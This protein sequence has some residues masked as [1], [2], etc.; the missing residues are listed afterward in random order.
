MCINALTSA[1]SAI[2]HGIYAVAKGIG[3]VVSSIC[4]KVAGIAARI[5]GKAP[6]QSSTPAKPVNATPIAESQNPKQ[7]ELG[8]RVHEAAAKKEIGTQTETPTSLVQLLPPKDVCL[9]VQPRTMRHAAVC[10]EIRRPH[11][12]GIEKPNPRIDQQFLTFN[13]EF[14]LFMNLLKNC[15]PITINVSFPKN[16]KPVVP[17]ASKPALLMAPE[18]TPVMAKKRREISSEKLAEIMGFYCNKAQ[19]RMHAALNM[20]GV[21]EQA[22]REA[23]TAQLKKSKLI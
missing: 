3:H 21:T 19:G 20:A 17:V 16:A 13:R 2:S 5:F 1:A 15:K 8:Q 10:N 22:D 7:K 18:A 4:H 23:A 11:L 14:L 9:A 12:E 6:S